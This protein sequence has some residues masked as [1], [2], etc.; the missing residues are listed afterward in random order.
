MF[1]LF[2]SS[3][4]YHAVTNEKIKKI[5]QKIDHSA[6]Y[7]LIAGTYTPILLLTVKP[8]INIAML[9]IIWSLAVVGIGFSCT[10]LKSKYI[11]TGIYLIM[12]WL[13]AF[14]FYN[15]WM[16]SHLSAWLAVG[17]GIFYSLGCIFYLLKFRYMHSIWHLFVIAGALMHYFAI[18]GLLHVIH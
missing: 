16:A 6:I 1:L 17:G 10:T 9:A 8:P 4:C 5:F 12:G 7:L 13:S 15:M 3:A 11:S 18:M 14:L 2:Q